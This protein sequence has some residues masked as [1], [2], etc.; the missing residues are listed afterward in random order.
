MV[1]ESWGLG[2]W[3]LGGRCFLGGWLD[4]VRAATNVERASLRPAS[5]P[6]L[7]SQPQTAPK[8]REK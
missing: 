1:L 3:G 4:D 6:Y 5:N 2:S 8:N 7:K